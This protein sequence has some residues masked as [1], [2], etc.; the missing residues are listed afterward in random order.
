MCGW[1]GEDVRK[2][3]AGGNEHKGVSLPEGS[4]RKVVGGQEGDGWRGW[5]GK[6]ERVRVET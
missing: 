3:V 2:W 4:G 6:D 5:A 1:V